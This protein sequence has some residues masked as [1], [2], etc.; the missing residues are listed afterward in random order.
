MVPRCAEILGRSPITLCEDAMP[1]HP[2]VNV[3]HAGKIRG[4]SIVAFHNVIFVP[5]KHQ[6]GRIEHHRLLG[7][8][9]RNVAES[10]SL[11]GICLLF[12]HH[13]LNIAKV[14]CFGTCAGFPSM[15][16]Y[17]YIRECRFLSSCNLKAMSVQSVA[18][19]FGPMRHEIN[20]R[21]I[22]M[23]CPDMEAYLAAVYK[24]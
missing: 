9:F 21:T 4:R 2:R 23:A 5:N 3:D 12:V 6:L 17:V 15:L 1:D 10:H 24:L 14:P 13:V 11:I 22:M 8:E 16:T 20:E 19:R 18:N 7:A